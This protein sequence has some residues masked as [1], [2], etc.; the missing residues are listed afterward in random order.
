VTTI[1]C[2]VKM[3]G[4]LPPLIHMLLCRKNGQ[5]DFRVADFTKAFN[6]EFN[7]TQ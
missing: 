7:K 1:Y 2:R 6:Q 3:N 4:D 5:L